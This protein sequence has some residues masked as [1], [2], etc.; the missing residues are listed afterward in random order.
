MSFLTLKTTENGWEYVS[1][2]SRR[3]VA[4]L[5]YRYYGPFSL[6]FLVNIV[7]YPFENHLGLVVKQTQAITG[8]V[9]E[10]EHLFD[11]AVRE[12][13]EETG[14]DVA[15]SSDRVTYFGSFDVA[16]FSDA[17]VAM[18]AVDLTGVEPVEEAK[19]DGSEHE[20]S[21][22]SEWVPSYYLVG[23]G[24]TDMILALARMKFLELLSQRM[25]GSTGPQ[26]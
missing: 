2:P 14:Y 21:I 3:T 6:E 18:F 22:T 13:R 11:A 10:K 20:K 26:G 23:N 9:D 24:A 4:V 19:G 5:P 1:L 12:L 16:R 25:A 8:L 7:D 17:K 15:K